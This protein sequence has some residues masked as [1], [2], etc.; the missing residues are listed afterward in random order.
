MN[1]LAFGLLFLLTGCNLGNFGKPLNPPPGVQQRVLQQHFYNGKCQTDE[2][3]ALKMPECQYVFSVTEWTQTV[4]SVRLVVFGFD[5][6]WFSFRLGPQLTPLNV[7]PGQTF[8]LNPGHNV[9]AIQTQIQTGR[10]DLTITE[11][12]PVKPR[13]YVFSLLIGQDR[14]ISGFKLLDPERNI[15]LSPITTRQ[16]YWYSN[17]DLP[18]AV[19]SRGGDYFTASAEMTGDVSSSHYRD[20]KISDPYTFSVSCQGRALVVA[21]G[22]ELCRSLM[23]KNQIFSG[24]FIVL[25]Q[26]TLTK[27]Q[28]LAAFDPTE[29]TGFRYS[30]AMKD[31]TYNSEVIC[32]GSSF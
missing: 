23:P 14:K 1:R 6:F 27:G 26:A 7:I 21:D 25:K 9:T 4:M 28:C 30:V 11:D 22:S 15:S 29:S 16:Q 13:T 12:G 17:F 8:A 19:G 32:K 24:E 5:E 3:S 10:V 2:G 20:L 31:L 18:F